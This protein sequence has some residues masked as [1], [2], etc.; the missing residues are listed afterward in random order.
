MISCITGID[1]DR[2]YLQDLAIILQSFFYMCMGQ[3]AVAAVWEGVRHW[4]SW[5][6]RQIVDRDPFSLPQ[7][8]KRG[9]MEFYMPLVFYLFDFMVSLTMS[10][11]DHR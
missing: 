10:I 9:Q 4:G 11:M 5:Q 1:V 7:D 3:A 6:E 2:D 8:D